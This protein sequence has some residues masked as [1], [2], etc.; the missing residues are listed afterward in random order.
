MD[1]NDRK[2]AN[3]EITVHWKPAKCIHATTCY[4]ELIEVFNPR[5]RPWVN[6]EGASTEKIIDIV[7]R[8]PTDALT[9]EWKEPGK[10]SEKPP[11]SLFSEES[12]LKEAQDQGAEIRIMKNG[13]YVVEGDFTIIG[14]DGQELKKMLMTSFCRCG[15]SKEMPFC[16]GSHRIEDF[17][18]S[19]E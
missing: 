3:K 13:S 16:D 1:P 8:C 10:V 19:C 15:A 18:N 17:T 6:M 12:R 7:R 14:S 11:E 5:N 2:Y 4:R 9:Y